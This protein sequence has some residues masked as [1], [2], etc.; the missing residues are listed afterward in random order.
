MTKSGGNWLNCTI[1]NVN[2][3]SGYKTTFNNERDEKPT[4]G[5]K[6]L[7]KWTNPNDIDKTEELLD[8]TSLKDQA[9]DQFKYVI[10]KH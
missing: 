1:K 4:E 3:T 5:V 8:P 2:I 9:F 10:N 7:E 6:I